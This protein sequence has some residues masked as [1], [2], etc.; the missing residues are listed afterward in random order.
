MEGFSLIVPQTTISFLKHPR[1]KKNQCILPPLSLYVCNGACQITWKQR[2]CFKTRLQNKQNQAHTGI[3]AEKHKVIQ[4]TR[5][6]STDCRAHIHTRVNV[7]H[8]FQLI[9]P[10]T[11]HLLAQSWLS[12]TLVGA[13]IPWEDIHAP[14]KLLGLSLC[15]TNSHQQFC[16][17]EIFHILKMWPDRLRWTPPPWSTYHGMIA[18]CSVLSWITEGTWF[19][20]LSSFSKEIR[21]FKISGNLLF[22]KVF[23]NGVGTVLWKRLLILYQ[24]FQKIK[25][26][27]FI[28]ARPTESYTMEV[29]AYIFYYS[30]C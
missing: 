19:W 7:S 23:R 24:K 16:A 28:G 9:T 21:I 20:G 27:F 2:L 12:L 1:V 17:R 11:Q 3:L 5:L 25:T 13:A 26:F 6:R 10:L 8:L 14:E 4:S 15:V 29:R 18:H 22:T 30:Q